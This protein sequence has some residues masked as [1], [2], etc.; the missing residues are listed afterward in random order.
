ME[1]P[2]WATAAGAA[3]GTNGL[4]S[5]QVCLQKLSF[6]DVAGKN[7]SVAADANGQNGW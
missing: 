5:Y 7:H 3:W 2:L 1:N 4:G 6:R